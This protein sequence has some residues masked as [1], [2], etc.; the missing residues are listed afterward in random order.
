MIFTKF[1]VLKSG[2]NKCATKFPCDCCVCYI[3]DPVYFPP[4][5]RLLQLKVRRVIQI[6]GTFPFL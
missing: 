6:K 4:L 5:R 2:A 3:C 1:E